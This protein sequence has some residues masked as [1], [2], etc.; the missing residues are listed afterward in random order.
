MDDIQDTTSPRE[1]RF[2][3]SLAFLQALG[4][5]VTHVTQKF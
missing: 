5:H 1:I 3:V 4:V 2:S